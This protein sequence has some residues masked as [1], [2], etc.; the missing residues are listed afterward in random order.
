MILYPKIA[1]YLK[2]KS[3]CLVGFGREGQSSYHYIRKYFPEKP[4]VIA[5]KNEI[6]PPDAN[7]TCICGE[8]YLDSLSDFDLVLK[9]PGISFKDVDFPFPNTEITCQM[10]LF[11]RFAPCHKIGVTGSKGK[12]TTS[13]LTYLFLQKACVPCFLIGNIGIP[14]FESLENLTE[15]TVA[16]I[17]MSSHQLEFT[18]ASPEVCVL[19][20]LYEEHLEHY[21]GGFKG[22]ARAKSNIARYQSTDDLFLYNATQGLPEAIGAEDFKG[23][24]R[25]IEEN[26]HLPFAVQNIHL[27]GVH[28]HQDVAFAYVATKRF[29]VTFEDCIE[30]LKAY[31]GIEHRMELVGTFRGITFYNDCIA[32]IPHAVFCAVDAL[33]KVD[34]LIVGG[35]DRGLNYD[36]FIED[37]AK[38]D[39][40][41]ILGTPDTGTAI[42]KAL[43]E[44][45]PEKNA[46]ACA[47]LEEAV[48]YAYAH[49]KEGHIC[50]L[51][52]AA[53][54]YN[55]YK[56]FEEKG[57]HYKALIARYSNG[58]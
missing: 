13:T 10:D 40:S 32:T 4:L 23:E 57:K 22:Y 17:E 14:V 46:V 36:E 49:T 34:T 30:A 21:K 24:K 2:D 58:E 28:N 41:N 27:L 6:T 5:D 29:G 35:K 54:S 11:L 3:I 42:V 45:Y 37:L 52:P 44:R 18:T 15:D 7:T 1:E 9:S 53:S 39:I 56:N 26:F 33:E 19:T 43:N 16:V 50:L 31:Q 8:Q 20:N 12:T 51:S 48:K 55:V 38:S 47:D 25:G